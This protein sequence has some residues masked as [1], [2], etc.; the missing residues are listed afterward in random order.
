MMIHIVTIWQQGR[1]GNTWKMVQNFHKSKVTYMATHTVMH[2]NSWYRIL[3][4]KKYNRQKNPKF[5]TL[6][7]FKVSLL[8]F[9]CEK[10]A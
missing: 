1:S 9:G 6:K 10:H 2:G 8:H 7:E 4:K 5:T 3:K